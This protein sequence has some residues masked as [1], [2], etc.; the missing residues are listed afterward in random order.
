MLCNLKSLPSIGLLGG[1]PMLP[2]VQVPKTG[3]PVFAARL[4]D[5]TRHAGNTSGNV[6]RCPLVSRNHPLYTCP[7]RVVQAWKLVDKGYSSRG[8]ES[9]HIRH[10]DKRFI[11]SIL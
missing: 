1:L 5:D 9:L 6:Q 11:Y 8:F 10:S 7:Q 2:P 4:P 3:E